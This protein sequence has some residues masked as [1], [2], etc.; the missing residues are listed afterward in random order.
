MSIGNSVAA[1]LAQVTIL[2]SAAG[3]RNVQ[4]ID[5]CIKHPLSELFLTLLLREYA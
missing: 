1:A 4:G 2:N 5:F 3:Y